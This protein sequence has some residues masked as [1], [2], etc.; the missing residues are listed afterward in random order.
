MHSN[1]ICTSANIAISDTLL[2]H[3]KDHPEEILGIMAH[4]IGHWDMMHIYWE[5]PMNTL[6]MVILTACYIKMLNDPHLLAS[7]GFT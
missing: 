4:E 3:H 6:Y 2:A 1:A 5:I 7:F